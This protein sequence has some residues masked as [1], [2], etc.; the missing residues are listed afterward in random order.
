[1]NILVCISSVP[2]TTTKIRFTDDNKAFDTSEVK[3]IINPWDELALTRALELKEQKPDQVQ[4]I[5]VAT[6]G[7][8]WTEQVIRKALAIGA[9]KGLR[10]DTEPKD[11]WQTASQLLPVVQN[12][13]YD[14]VMAGIDSSDYNG[15]AVGNMLA[16]MAELPS[17]AAVSYLDLDGD[18]ITVKREVAGGKETMEAKTPFVAIVQKGIAIEPKIAG[19]RGVMNARRKPLE[20]LEPVS[21]EAMTEFLSF[22]LPE[23]KGDC[24][25]IEPG[26]ESELFDK[27]ANEA[28]AL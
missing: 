28:N 18:K 27:L 10:V 13:N 9:D 2:E 19:M 7:G 12:G 6:V 23:P 21:A 3:W 22:E 8:Q 15:M 14:I 17:I 1:M 11:A 5:T 25:M 24:I 20:I 26:N 4:E 16:E